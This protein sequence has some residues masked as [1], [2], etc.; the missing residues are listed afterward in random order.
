[1]VLDP[2][3]PPETSVRL[4]PELITTKKKETEHFFKM[5]AALTYKRLRDEGV[6]A[7]AAIEE[8]R[9]WS[10][11]NDESNFY[12]A[13]PATLDRWSKLAKRLRGG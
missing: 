8:A 9:K 13:L 5:M 2:S 4:K 3:D 11:I 10:Q 12:H 1:M 7:K 6:S